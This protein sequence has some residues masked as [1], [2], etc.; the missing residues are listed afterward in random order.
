MLWAWKNLGGA[1]EYAAVAETFC[2]QV[3]YNSRC[4]VETAIYRPNKLAIC[5]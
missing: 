2:I 5:L 1:L 4:D 3:K